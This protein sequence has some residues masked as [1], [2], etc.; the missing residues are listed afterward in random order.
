MDIRELS[1]IKVGLFGIATPEVPHLSSPGPDV[2]VAPPVEAAKAAVAELRRQGAQVIVAVTHL[3]LADD[4]ALIR[5]IAGIDVVIGGHDHD[6]I[7]F[8]EGGTLIN[9]DVFAALPFTT[10]VVLV[11]LSGADLMAA[12]E[13]GV[14]QIEGKAGRF[15]QVAGLRLEYDPKAPAGR[16]VTKVTIGDQPL[17]PARTY[18]VATNDF[19]VSGGDGYAVLAKGKLLTD[20]RAAQLMSNVVMAYIQRKGMVAPEL[21]GRNLAKP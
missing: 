6:P 21:D 1:G 18:K 11:A 20:A 13:N 17:D 8:Y 9:K 12:L 15:P 16:R 2:A 10:Y 19:M 14:S 5:A 3:D 7:T 4:R